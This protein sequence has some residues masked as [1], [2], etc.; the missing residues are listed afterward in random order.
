[1][2][3]EQTEISLGVVRPKIKKEVIFQAIGDFKEIKNMSSS[4]GCSEPSWDK[5][6]KKL[7][8]SY[9]P[10]NIPL[11]LTQQNKTEYKTK[12]S[13]TLYY[14]DGTNQTLTFTATVRK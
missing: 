8:V 12:K 7:T 1:M 10:A 3:W 4:C 9:N 13:I 6:S 5:P 2:E 14:D 11:H